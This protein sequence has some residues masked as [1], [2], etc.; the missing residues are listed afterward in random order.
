MTTSRTFAA[1]TAVAA[2][3]TGVGAAHAYEEQL[4]H[5]RNAI[6]TTAAACD[7]RLV[8]WLTQAGFKGRHVK[9]AWAVAMRESNGQPGEAS[10]PD[11]GLF[12]LNAPTW[13]GS[14]YWPQ[15]VFDPVQNARA[16]KRMV[17]DHGW[18]PWGLRVSKG[19]V[20]YDFSSYGGWSSWQRQNWIIEPFQRY[21]ALFP[22][23]CKPQPMQGPP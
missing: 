18:Q 15:D 22:R 17:N 3:T 14:K 11:L 5:P 23:E 2:L 13:Q 19:Q 9:V 21:S 8:G 7:D 4:P 1:L 20:S 16:V 10:W 6:L 12:Q